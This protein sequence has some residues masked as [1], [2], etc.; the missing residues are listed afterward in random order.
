MVCDLRSRATADNTRSRVASL[1]AAKLARA[2]H[3]DLFAVVIDNAKFRG[4]RA[5]LHWVN[6]QELAQ[7]GRTNRADECPIGGKA[8]VAVV[9]M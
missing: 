7:S 9:R 5:S 2:A 8:D 1:A 6:R 3:R 4:A